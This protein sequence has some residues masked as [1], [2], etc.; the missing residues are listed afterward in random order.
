MEIQK[1]MYGLPQAGIL[2]NKLLKERLGKKGY[3]EVPHSPGLWTH[4]WRPITF[5]LVVDD[6]GIKYQGKEYFN[7]LLSTLREDYTVEVDPAGSLY[8][9][10]TLKWNYEKGF[11]DISMPGYV[12]KQLDRYGHSL[13]R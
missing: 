2:A 12:Q 1:G 10:I 4:T 5:T 3:Y 8:C 6:F 7:H 11:V 13:K 9:G